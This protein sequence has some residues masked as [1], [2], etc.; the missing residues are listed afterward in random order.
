MDRLE[1]AMTCT[2]TTLFF[3]CAAAVAVATGTVAL[4]RYWRRWKAERMQRYS[5]GDEDGPGDR[6]QAAAER[7]E[8]ASTW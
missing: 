7:P 8:T 2:D 3:V 6:C 4:W 5:T 1:V